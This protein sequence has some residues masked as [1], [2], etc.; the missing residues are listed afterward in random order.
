MSAVLLS[1]N[2]FSMDLFY[3]GGLFCFLRSLL[4]WSG[5]A[6]SKLLSR[7]VEEENGNGSKPPRTHTHFFKSY[8]CSAKLMFF[9]AL[10]LLYTGS[11]SISPIKFGHRCLSAVLVHPDQV[12][13]NPLMHLL[14]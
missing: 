10:G 14:L 3:V 1:Q 12:T 9:A 7:I 13:E 8:D 2:D 11:N 5:S 6:K 4:Q